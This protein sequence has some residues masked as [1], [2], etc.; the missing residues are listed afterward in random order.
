MLYDRFKISSPINLPQLKAKTMTSQPVEKIPLVIGI[1]GHRNLHPEEIELL[2]NQ[3][4][5]LFQFL[6]QR[7]PDTPLLLLS[8]LAEG[9]DRLVAKVALAEQ[10]R[11]IVPLPLPITEYQRDFDTPAL[12]QEFTE[13][14]NQAADVFVLPQL[15]EDVSQKRSD[16]RNL[17]YVLV[18]AYVA[19][20][21]HILLG[22]WDGKTTSESA[23][24]WGSTYQV[25][26]FRLT[27]DMRGL[28]ETYRPS[29]NPLNLIDTGKV[30]HFKVSR[31]NDPSRALDAGELSLLS[32]PEHIERGKFNDLL[33]QL[34]SPELDKINEFNQAVVQKS[35]R[36]FKK[37]I[38]P[39][40]IRSRLKLGDL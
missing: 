7:Y 40:N 2:Q 31:A 26:Q 25:I 9:A 6:R 16:A 27:G 1:T 35:G 4:R 8:P 19:R 11:L 30:C 34:P 23:Q 24:A 37:P 29:I 13:L 5:Q 17:Q 10:M 22:L 36:L 12:R 15:N 18:G 28:P 33:A 14:Q 21:S 38:L 32:P 20:H 3:V 39:P